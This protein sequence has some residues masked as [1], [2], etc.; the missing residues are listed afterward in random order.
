MRLNVKFF[1]ILLIAGIMGIASCTKEK[2]KREVP[3]KEQLIS[4]RLSGTWATPGNIV[5]P[6]NVPAEVFGTMRLV[7]TTDETG[8][9]SKFL[10]QGCPII[11]GNA[12][13][14]TWTVAG[15]DDSAK[16][17]LTGVDPVDEFNVSVTSSTLTISFYMGWENTDTKATGKGNFQV[18]LTRQ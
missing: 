11:F 2:L 7:F 4:G 17:N 9:P 12:G 3:D 8:N 6:E 5:T 18:T 13:A 1:L 14:G 16:V 15:T 10:A